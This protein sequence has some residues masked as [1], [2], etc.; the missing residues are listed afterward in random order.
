MLSRWLIMAKKCNHGEKT[1]PS[2]QNCYFFPMG[3]LGIRA[4]YTHL[5]RG[6]CTKKIS[7]S[8]CSTLSAIFGSAP[9]RENRALKVKQKLTIYLVIFVYIYIFNKQRLYGI[10]MGYNV[11]YNVGYMGFIW[12]IHDPGPRFAGP[13][14]SGMVPPTGKVPPV[15]WPPLPHH[16][17]ER[18]LYQGIMPMDDDHTTWPWVGG[19]A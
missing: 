11:G 2:P 8:T 4:W 9:G 7:G 6:S 18:G 14:C 10:Y 19:W 3:N 17:G 12:D 1:P 16:R 13:P 5:S 15:V